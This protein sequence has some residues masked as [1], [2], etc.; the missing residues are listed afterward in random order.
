[1]SQ[2]WRATLEVPNYW[3][4]TF[5]DVE[6]LPPVPR[7]LEEQWLIAGGSKLI[8]PNPRGGHINVSNLRRRVWYAALENA[9]LKRRDL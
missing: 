5:R 9:G 7:A 6:I 8:F 4:R 3:G 1:V 2:E